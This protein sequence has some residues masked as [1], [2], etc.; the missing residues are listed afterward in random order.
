MSPAQRDGSGGN[1]EPEEGEIT[2]SEVEEW[3]STPSISSASASPAKESPEL[4]MEIQ[5]RQGEGGEQAEFK[6][7]QVKPLDN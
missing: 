3:E 1:S 2:E 5:S 7:V 6:A 4:E